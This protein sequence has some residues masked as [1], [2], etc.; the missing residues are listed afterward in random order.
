M[1]LFSKLF[2]RKK[3]VE[4]IGEDVSQ[5]VEVFLK[6][7]HNHEFT[8]I[9][10][11]ELFAFVY[12][13]VDFTLCNNR[14]QHRDSIANSMSQAFYKIVDNVFNDIDVDLQET[15]LNERI[16][17]YGS[18]ARSHI[19]PSEIF[20]RADFYLKQGSGLDAHHESGATHS[21]V[22]IG[23][24]FSMLGQ[25]KELSKFYTESLAPLIRTI[26]SYHS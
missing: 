17:E 5:L 18:M 23:D 22:V 2:E 7:S 16:Q 6:S 20:K 3:S 12:F 19:E 4:S 13:Q 24:V 21:P 15:V 26:L 11:T 14:I 25:T 1:N 10:Y 8:P 9:T